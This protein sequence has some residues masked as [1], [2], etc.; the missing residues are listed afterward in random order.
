MKKIYIVLLVVLLF[1][2]KNFDRTSATTEEEIKEMV[3][4]LASDDLKGRNTGTLEISEAAKYIEDKFKS[5]GIKPYFEGYQDEFPIDS[6]KGFNVVGVL[7]GNDPKLKD[8]Y[9]ILGAHY[10]HIGYGKKVEQDS[11]ANGANDNASGSAA[12]LAMAKHFASEKTNKR[13]I[14]FVL[15]SAEEMG[16]LGSG[17]LAKKLKEEN[18]NLYTMLNFEMIGVPFTGRDYD[19]FVTGYDLSN[20]AEKLNN[21]NGSKF[22]GFSEIAKKYGLFRASDNYPFY[23]EFKLPCHTLSSCDLTNYNFY[24]KVG[25]EAQLMDYKYMASIINKM[26]P[27]IETVCNTPSQEIKMN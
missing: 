18:F 8:E 13:S 20:V 22:V 16:L 2:F 7:E 1:N 4:F 23:Q 14:M 15:F 26:M 19:V 5:Y 6:L 25:D 10:D 11:I 21:Y 12:V 17:H 27:V 3:S 24:H 9:V